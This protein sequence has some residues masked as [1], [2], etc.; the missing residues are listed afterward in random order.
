MMENTGNLQKLTKCVPY[1]D[2]SGKGEKILSDGD[3][4]I[5]QMRK[6]KQKAEALYN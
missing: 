1:I 2:N 6:M 3:G 5:E 4:M